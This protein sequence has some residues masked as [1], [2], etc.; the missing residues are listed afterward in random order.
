MSAVALA[1][2][3]SAI[4]GGIAANKAAKQQKQAAQAAINTQNKALDQQ[5]VIFDTQVSNLEPFRQAGLAGQNRLLQ[6]LGLGGDT[7]ASDYG[8]LNK[9]YTPNQFTA[10]QFNYDQYSDPSTQFRLKEGL[11]ALQSTAAARGGLLSGATLKA[12][13]RYG[14]DLAS[15]EYQNA[16]SRY[17]TNRNSAL[18]EF[19]TNETNRVNAFNTNRAN[20]IQPLEFLSGLGRDAVNSINGYAGNYGNAIGANGQNISSAQIDRGNAAAAGTVGTVNA[21]TNAL[22]QGVDIYQQ[23]RL[24]NS[25]PKNTTSYVPQQPFFYTNYALPAR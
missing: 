21:I 18:N 20:A 8:S 5:K 24:L 3:G 11:K 22:G 12:A 7:Q 16:F 6:Q 19:N 2:G 17:Q 25:L 10:D 14:Q 1:V 4:L 23:N 13:S 15:Q 9:Q